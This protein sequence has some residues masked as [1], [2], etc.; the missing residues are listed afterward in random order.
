[1]LCSQGR[2][3][4][5]SRYEGV[6]FKPQVPLLLITRQHN[7]EQTNDKLTRQTRKQDA[8]LVEAE[9]ERGCCS[10]DNNLNFA[11]TVLSLHRLSAALFLFFIPLR[12]FT[13]VPPSFDCDSPALPPLSLCACYLTLLFQ[14]I[15]L[16]SFCP[17]SMTGL[18]LSVLR[19]ICIMLF[20]RLSFQEPS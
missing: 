12:V 20:S 14:W 19:L 4:C 1:M 10:L 2:F 11:V 5:V 16:V 15:C 18:P 7:L 9:G 13:F 17:V 6:F 3:A 8:G